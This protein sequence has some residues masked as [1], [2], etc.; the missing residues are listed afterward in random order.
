M[1]RRGRR[2][3]QGRPVALLTLALTVALC[4]GGIL[5]ARGSSWLYA[6]EGVFR[7]ETE[8]TYRLSLTPEG[9]SFDVTLPLLLDVEQPWYRVAIE[10]Q[11]VVSDI[12]WRT[13]W[14]EDDPWG[15]PSRWATLTWGATS[16]E[17]C[18]ERIVRAVS[19]AEYGVIRLRDAY[20]VDPASVP[21][22]GYDGLGPTSQIQS[23]DPAIVAIAESLA[24]GCRT[25]LEVV[26]R[27][28]GY[29][30]RTVR[31]A[32]G[33]ELCDPVHRTD[34]LATYERGIGNCVSY[35]NLALALLRAVGIPS[36]DAFGFVADRAESSA[37]HAWISVHFPSRGWVEFES[38]DWIPGYGEAP[39]TFLMPQHVTIGV[40]G[41]RG[42]SQV[43]FT[44]KHL[45]TFEILERPERTTELHGESHPGEA[46]SWVLTL[47]AD[48]W[49]QHHF[50]LALDGVP[51]G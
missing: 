20:P 40:N 3:L 10:S 48:D 37:G 49:E 51:D 42:V 34:A 43:T 38:A 5:C 30:R 36:V 7:Q 29:V 14:E 23:G 4:A 6:L 22:E 1:V 31:Y 25:E 47:E 32:C 2:R 21:I 26:V 12:P 35:A 24:A 18:V 46:I 16:D 11:E 13:R 50:D 15:W 17:V 44:E 45:S 8:Y 9:E 39:V 19:E 41:Q 27:L 28:L 33:R